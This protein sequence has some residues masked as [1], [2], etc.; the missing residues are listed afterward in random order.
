MVRIY[1]QGGIKMI[2]REE[3]NQNIRK[4]KIEDN[5]KSSHYPTPLYAGGDEDEDDDTDDD[6]DLS[7]DD[8]DLSDDDED[9]EDEEP[10][11]DDDEDEA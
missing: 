3:L 8:D 10:D 5:E 1:K 7:D 6:D 9:S 2:K 11:T 4:T